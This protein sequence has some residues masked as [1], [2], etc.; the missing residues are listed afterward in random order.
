MVREHGFEP[1]LSRTDTSKLVVLGIDGRP[2]EE[3]A[4]GFAVADLATSRTGH[5]LVTGTD[6]VVRAFD[7]ATWRRVAEGYT[8]ADW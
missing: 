3:V 5:L 6:K 8:A 4:L 1:M 7:G 2:A